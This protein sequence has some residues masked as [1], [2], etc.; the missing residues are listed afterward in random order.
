MSPDLAMV[1]DSK[2]F[3]WDGQLYPTKEDASRAEES[4]RKDN[5]EVQCV[6]EGQQFLVYTRRVAKEVATAS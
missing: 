2:K 5:F 3:M 6:E 1:R 4:Y